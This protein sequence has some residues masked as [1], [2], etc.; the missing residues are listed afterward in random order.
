MSST[1]SHSYP[2]SSGEDQHS[3]IHNSSYQ[4]AAIKGVEER[5]KQAIL[6]KLDLQ[7][8]SNLI[9]TFTIADFGCS[10][11]PN[12]FHVVQ[13]I[14]DTVK[15]KHLKENN[16][17]NIV[18]LEFQVFFNDQSNND[19]N[20]LF[21][22][23]PLSSESQYF[24]AGVPG[25]FYG[26][27]LPRNIIHIGHTS[28]TIHWLSEVPEHVCDRKSPAWNKN[29]IHC[30]NLI[31]E[32]T[33]AYKVQFKKDMEVFLQ[34]RAEELVH[35]GLMIVVGNCLPDGVSMYETW[36]GHV[37]ETI[38][39]CL[40]DM[41]KSGIMS[42]EKIELFNFPVYFPQFSELKLMI[43]ENGSFMIE[44]METISHPFE[45]KR[46]SNEFITS[47]F[48]A[49]LTTVIEQHFG[50]GVVDELFS[51]LSEKL[52]KHPIDFE[53]WKTQVVYHVVLKRK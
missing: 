41:A 30:N 36:Q 12:T 21:R 5:I 39:D 44:M 45:D 50:N 10:I 6:E 51:R 53:M 4:K 29:Y 19:F 47:M 17:T 52:S 35:G 32:V 40:L 20:T 11:G 7:L 9:S 13:S 27:L 23:Q 46:L 18:P 49:F 38:G 26:R 16:E 25:S 37:M 34:A 43:E 14:I 1:S 33:K 42:E 8:N 22:T 3:Y 31:E 15:F 28:Y 48:R 24:L 2:M